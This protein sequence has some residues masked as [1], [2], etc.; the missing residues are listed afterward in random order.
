M[1]VVYFWGVCSLCPGGVGG[2]GCAPGW[3]V[4]LQYSDIQLAV[5]CFKRACSAGQLFPGKRI[6]ILSPWSL[7]RTALAILPSS[8]LCTPHCNSLNKTLISIKLSLVHLVSKR[9]FAF[10]RYHTGLHMSMHDS[11]L[12]PQHESIWHSSLHEAISVHGPVVIGYWWLCF[13]NTYWL[14]SITFFLAYAYVLF[15]LPGS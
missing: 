14:L 11:D 9:T 1:K 12:N 5:G 3:H 8:M 6:L 7:A 4:A 15:P 10:K 2:S 13:G